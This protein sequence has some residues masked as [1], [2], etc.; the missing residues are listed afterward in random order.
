MKKNKPIK[1]KRDQAIVADPFLCSSDR[2]RIFKMMHGYY[3]V[4][5]Y[6]GKT[7]LPDTTVLLAVGNRFKQVQVTDILY[8]ND[9]QKCVLV[10]LDGK[11][12]REVD[13]KRCLAITGG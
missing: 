8:N 12:S 5:D 9:K 3:E 13:P 10:I 7:I 6:A 4:R 11:K 1:R 2:Q